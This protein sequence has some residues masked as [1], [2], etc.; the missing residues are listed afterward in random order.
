MFDEINEGYYVNTILVITNP[1]LRADLSEAYNIG[2]LSVTLSFN[3]QCLF[4][5]F[6]TGYGMLSSRHPGS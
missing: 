4:S 3:F 2:D 1:A 6:N 5:R